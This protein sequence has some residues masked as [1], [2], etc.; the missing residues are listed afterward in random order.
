MKRKQ[1][2]AP[3]PAQPLSDIAASLPV[4]PVSASTSDLDRLARSFADDF[5]VFDDQ[6]DGSV[7]LEE[8]SQSYAQILS[9]PSSHGS[10]A[11]QQVAS[12]A[13]D[14]QDPDSTANDSA[15]KA[16]QAANSESAGAVGVPEDTSN[17]RYCAVTPLNIVEAVLLVGRPDS[18]PI[19]ATEIAALMRGVTEAEVDQL[20]VQLNQ[21][22]AADQRA[23]YVASVGG[24]YRLQVAEDLNYLRQQM[25][26]PA[27]PV[28]L[29]QQAIDCLALVS[30]QPG[31]SREKLDSQ[32]GKPCGGVLNQLVRRQLLEM[33]REK[34][35]NQLQPHYYP[36]PR[37]LELAGLESLDDLPTAEEWSQPG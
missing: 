10:T 27:R 25:M 30:Y 24:G 15:G 9:N 19:T 23:F 5:D 21:G 3:N 12:L 26:G 36:T 1:S 2:I 17:D 16:E 34:A 4:E 7:S 28:R 18:G 29:N 8:L 22:Y 32:I 37:L 35:G 14:G 13:D 11:Q 6:S 33:R 31:I 20:V